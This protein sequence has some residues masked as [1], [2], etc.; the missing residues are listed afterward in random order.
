MHYRRLPF[1]LR[2]QVHEYYYHKYHGQLFNEDG[3]LNELSHP[4]KEVVLSLSTNNQHI[5]LN[6]YIII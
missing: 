3:I 2:Q 5:F 6:S 4:L 1:D